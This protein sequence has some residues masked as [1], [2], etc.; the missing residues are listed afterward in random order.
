MMLK[1]S[2]RM[3]L[4]TWRAGWL[5]LAC[6]SALFGMV[7]L[8]GCKDSSGP[9]EDRVMTIEIVSG[10]QQQATVGTALPLPLVIRAVD[11]QGKPVGGATVEWDVAAANGTVTP[12]GTVTAN[13]GRASASWVI[14]NSATVQSLTIR[15][16]TVSATMSATGLAGPAATVTITPASVMLDAIGASADLAATAKDAHDNPITGR[17]FAWTSSDGAVVSVDA[18]GRVQ[19]TGMG[20]AKVRATL[21]GATGEADVMVQPLPATISL[22]PPSA[23]FTIVGATVQFVVSAKDRNGF[24][25]NLPATAYAWTTTDPAVVTVDASGLATSKG[26]GSALVRASLG[27]AS[28]QAQVTVQQTATTLVVSPAADTLTTAK[29]SVQLMVDA[30]D[31]NNQ[32]ILSPTLAWATS[33]AAVANVTNTGLVTAV[34]NGTAIIRVT[35]GA[36]K[37]SATI[38]VRLN[39]PAVAVIDSLAA[40]MNTSL[41]L[42]APGLLANDTL[43]VPSAT[44]V[45]FGGGSLLGTIATNPAG[46]TVM[47]G[48]GGSIRVSADGS[49]VFTPST[50]FTGSFTFQYRLQ[51]TAGTSDAT[52]VIEVGLPPMAVDDGYATAMNVALT[53]NAPGVLVNDNA[54]FPLSAVVSFG[55]G[56]LPGT[57]TSF[58]A[59][60]GLAFGIGAFLG[61]FI[62]LNADGSL[63]FT[64]PTG[65]TGTFTVQ[66]RISNGVGT[67]DATIS[68][69]VS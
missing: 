54:G 50:G 19:A 67:S 56:S 65:Y 23:Q 69:T 35:S 25:L 24:S 43:G 21:D 62:R 14:G 45:S 6:G 30:R 51:N 13:D 31:S 52:V 26:S 7:T 66:Y 48:T 47:F 34:A 44:I 28:G 20:S 18:A 8:A 17:S 2:N 38:V 49:I 42:A 63:S 4:A 46:S 1:A 39:A 32:P 59:G 40:L 11:A 16:K 5:R 27:N 41:V 36:A 53:V 10:D 61:G 60:Q 22:N 57:I 9:P 33:D 68:I 37:D 12:A 3:G 58:A 55:G 64:P 29:P 15:I